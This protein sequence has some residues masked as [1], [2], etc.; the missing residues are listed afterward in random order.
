MEHTTSLLLATW[1]VLV[2]MVSTHYTLLKTCIIAGM[3]RMYEATLHGPYWTILSGTVVTV[4]GLASIMWTTRTSKLV[5]QKAQPLG[6]NTS[7]KDED[8]WA[9]D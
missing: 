5:T 7:L 3:D 6:F 2:L 4:F 8:L 9:V 1:V